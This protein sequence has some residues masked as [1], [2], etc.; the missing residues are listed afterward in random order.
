MEMMEAVR[1]DI[2]Q[3]Q[4]V[5]SHTVTMDHSN[6][7]GEAYHLLFPRPAT[8]TSPLFPFM[9]SFYFSIQEKELVPCI[10]VDVDQKQNERSYF[11][12]QSLRSSLILDEKMGQQKLQ[13]EMNLLMKLRCPVVFFRYKYPNYECFLYCN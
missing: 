13:H 3:V 11:K 12:F 6:L 7:F 5:Q 2:I 10:F 8:Q 1:N 4:K 9:K